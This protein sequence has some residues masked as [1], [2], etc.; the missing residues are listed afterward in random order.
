MQEVLARIDA[1][2][3]K[4]HANDVRLRIEIG[5]IMADLGVF[6][7]GCA[8]NIVGFEISIALLLFENF[9]KTASRDFY[10]GCLGARCDRRITRH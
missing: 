7:N 10:E 3:R 1:L 5:R 2:Y 8:L 4:S 6:F 9:N